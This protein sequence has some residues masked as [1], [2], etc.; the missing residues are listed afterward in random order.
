MNFLAGHVDNGQFITANGEKI[1]VNAAAPGANTLGI[2]PERLRL[3][4]APEH[5][6]VSIPVRLA[7]RIY[8]ARPSNCAS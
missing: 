3:A 4:A 5:S 1:T 2:R 6:E 8:L 7:D